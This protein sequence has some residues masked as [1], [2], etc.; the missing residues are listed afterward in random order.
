MGGVAKV[1]KSVASFATQMTPLGG[2]AG[3]FGLAQ[4]AL[5]FAQGLTK[6]L[7]P[8]SPKFMSQLD[9]KMLGFLGHA[10]KALGGAAKYLADG[11]KPGAIAP[12]K[13]IATLHVNISPPAGVAWT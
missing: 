8:L 3:L 11:A 7:K 13:P 4:K 5:G 6:A 2:A 1:F 12:P 10:N 9:G